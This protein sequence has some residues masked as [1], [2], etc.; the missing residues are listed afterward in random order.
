MKVTNYH[1]DKVFDEY[2]GRPTKGI[3]PRSVKVGQYGWLGNPF[4]KGD[5]TKNI[6]DYKQYF[7][8]RINEDDAFREAVIE[9]QDKIVCCFCSPKP[10]HLNVIQAWFDAGMPLRSK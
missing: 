4:S 3:D 10:C 9:L 7:W 8:K 2:G 1:T 6:G 5:R